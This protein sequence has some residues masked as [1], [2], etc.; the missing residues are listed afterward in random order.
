VGLQ[1]RRVRRLRSV[2]QPDHGLV[3]L[4]LVQLHRQ[5]TA[6][7][8]VN[9]LGDAHQAV[10]TPVVPQECRAEVAFA[11]RC[12]GGHNRP[13][14]KTWK[15]PVTSRIWGWSSA[16][17]WR[18]GR[19][20]KLPLPSRPALAARGRQVATGYLPEAPSPSRGKSDNRC[21]TL[22]AL[23]TMVKSCGQT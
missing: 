10:G 11:E 2:H 23:H 4:G 14:Q 21:E 18:G 20:Q 3:V 6:G 12:D 19:V 22:T 5:G 16:L 8:A 17:P 15:W 13:P 1:D 9:L 7:V